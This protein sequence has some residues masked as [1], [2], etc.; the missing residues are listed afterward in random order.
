MLDWSDSYSYSGNT[1]TCL[2]KVEDQ[3]QIFEYKTIYK[4]DE[5]QNVK[6][7]TCE[8]NEIGKPEIDQGNCLMK[9]D[10]FQAQN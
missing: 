8:Y 9:T 7:W 2:E 10:T 3:N 6:T 4:L 1:I 5:E